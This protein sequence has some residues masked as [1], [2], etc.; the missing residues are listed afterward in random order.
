MTHDLSAEERSAIHRVVDFGAC[1]F[2]AVSTV[3]ARAGPF[4][5]RTL[6]LQEANTQLGV[7]AERRDA[8]CVICFGLLQR[9]EAF[10]VALVGGAS[11]V[12]R[13]LPP[14]EM[15]RI[16]I[17]VPVGSLIR[18]HLV[19]HAV[20]PHCPGVRLAPCEVKTVAKQRMLRAL[21][22]AQTT[23]IDVPRSELPDVPLECRIRVDHSDGVALTRAIVAA[24]DTE[25]PRVH[26]HGG[27][28]HRGSSHDKRNEFF[29]SDEPTVHQ[30]TPLLN[31]LGARIVE[32]FPQPPTPP[33][34]P[35][36]VLVDFVHDSI[37][38]G[39]RYNKWAR[40]ISQSPWTIDESQTV[41]SVED[42]FMPSLHRLFGTVTHALRTAGR[43]D[44]DVRM[45]GSG[46]PFM[47]ELIH[48]DDTERLG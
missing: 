48:P 14:V 21:L 10:W 8:V 44:R 9:D 34:A 27:K 29:D 38:V 46:R 40:G 1:V 17:A 18:S 3:S 28:R 47:V 6:T 19:V 31:R 42:C 41:L 5:A 39:G 4:V 35:A 26:R 13:G 43:E 22:A 20:R 30:V 25:M 16:G 15:W 45:L 36:N 33:A 7:P 11:A 23:G 24:L 2:C 12:Y 37:W 32:A